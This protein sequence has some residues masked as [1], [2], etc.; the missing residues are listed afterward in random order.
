MLQHDFDVF[1]LMGRDGN[2]TCFLRVCGF[3]FSQ[4]ALSLVYL[5]YYCTTKNE[6][7]PRRLRWSG[8][9]SGRCFRAC[10][11]RRKGAD[12]KKKEEDKAKGERS[13]E[14]YYV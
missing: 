9:R 8:D 7:V 14:E 5:F 12:R 2:H 4:E 10:A 13:E 11:E 3:C 1:A 6:H